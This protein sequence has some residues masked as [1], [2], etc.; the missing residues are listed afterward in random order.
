MAQEQ[1]VQEKD[2]VPI[3]PSLKVVDFRTVNKGLRWWTAAV[4]IEAY[5]RKSVSLYL[6][7]K[8]EGQWKRK[9]KFSIQTKGKWQLL[10][11]AIDELLPHLEN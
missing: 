11:K 8:R 2:S 7:Q 3:S 5:G 1:P 9:Q 10:S 4:V 6:W